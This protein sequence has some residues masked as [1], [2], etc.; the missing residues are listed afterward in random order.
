[1]RVGAMM[2]EFDVNDV[3]EVVAQAISAEGDDSSTD[4]HK[5]WSTG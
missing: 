4:Q 3:I 1:M 2:C 5:Q